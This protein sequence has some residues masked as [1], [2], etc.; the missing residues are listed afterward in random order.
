MAGLTYRLEH[1]VGERGL[2][3]SMRDKGNEVFA[4]R[5]V[6]IRIVLTTHRQGATMD[7]KVLKEEDKLRSTE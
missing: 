1:G 3:L 5:E 4:D 7:T 2:S 6:G